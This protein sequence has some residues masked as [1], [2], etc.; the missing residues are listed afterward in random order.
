VG[1]EAFEGLPPFTEDG[2]LPEGDWLLTLDELRNSHLVKGSSA[3]LP[4]WNAEWRSMLIDNLEILVR[5][6]WIVGIDQIFIDGSFAE[7][8]AHPNDIDGYFD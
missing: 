7:D 4:G 1:K 3:S 5:Q 6:L 8:K 2:V